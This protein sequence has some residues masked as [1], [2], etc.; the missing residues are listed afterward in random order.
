[1]GNGGAGKGKGHLVVV[2][3]TVLWSVLWS[4]LCVQVMSGQASTISAALPWLG[5]SHQERPHQCAQIGDRTRET[6][7]R[8]QRSNHWA[9]TP[10][11]HDNSL[12]RATYTLPMQLTPRRA[13]TN[14]LT[15][16]PR[17]K[18]TTAEPA[19]VTGVTAAA[20]STS[21]PPPESTS[22]PQAESTPEPESEVTSEPEGTTEPESE[23]TSEPEGTTEPE[24]EVTS[25]P[26]GTTEPESEVTS[27]PEGT[28]EPE[29]VVT[30]EP[31]GSTEPES[32][33][34]S[35][36]EGSTEPE[37][38]VTS[39]PEGTIE[40]ESVV[41][42]E[43]ERSTE[44]ESEVTSEPEGSTEPESE[45]TSEPEGTTEPE[46]VVTSEPEG[47]IEPESEVTSEP[48]GT[49]EPESE[50]TSEPEG[51]TEPESEVTSEPEGTTEPESEVTSEPEGTIEPESEVTYEPEGTTE[52][53]SEVISESEGTIEPESEV[54]SEPEG[55]IE[56][57]SEVTS[58]PE[59]STE[60]ESEVASEPEGT[61]EPESEVTSEPEGTIEPESEV[62]SEPEGSTEP[63]PGVTSE[64]EGT[65]EPESEVTSE[66]ESEGSSEPEGTTEPESEANSEPESEGSS[67]PESVLTVP[68]GRPSAA[69][70]VI[71]PLLL[72]LGILFALLVLLIK[73]RRASINSTVYG[74]SRTF[75]ETIITRKRIGC[76]SPASDDIK[77]IDLTALNNDSL[78]PAV[79]TAAAGVGAGSVAEET[80]FTEFDLDVLQSLRTCYNQ[81]KELIRIAIPAVLSLALCPLTLYMFDPFRKLVWPEYADR[82]D[83]N[84]AIACYLSPAGLV[85]ATSFGFAFQQ[86]LNKQHEI[87]TKM[88]EEISMLDQI[89]TFAIK[90][91]VQLG[92]KLKILRAVKA[93]CIFMALQVLDR[94]IV[95]YRHKPDDDIK[96]K[97]WTVVDLLREV[98]TSHKNHIDRMLSER[99][100]SHIMKLNSICS[101]RMGIL[102]SRIHPFK[103]VFLETLGFFSFLGILLLTAH[104]YRMEL[105]MCIVTVF[106][107]SMLCYVVSDLDAPF[108]GFFRVDIGVLEEVLKRLDLIHQMAK[109]R[110]HVEVFYPE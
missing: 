7:D 30:S 93:E 82:P 95:S 22:E 50:V 83:I 14:P 74:V 110:G 102:H 2:M 59:G 90:L 58:E 86:V 34:T 71:P 91:H 76:H 87:L 32:E 62:T 67:E 23:V 99:I 29:S 31:E 44:P 48:E 26:E 4:V 51:T 43:P 100:L 75:L 81:P 69:E 106:S 64:Q 104:S 1:M 37:S 96:V 35:E 18:S 97:I 63:E 98:D 103:W 3:Q 77:V 55:T 78:K 20:E 24:P 108:S 79:Q 53:E 38:E 41:T 6:L 13:L 66:P 109:H 49:I 25:E 16:A 105:V 39:E 42:S 68:E 17:H 72:I 15:W 88:T 47:S 11:H 61:I 56:P 40:P 45:V 8:M 85:Y 65:T 36:P 73:S 107:I 19:S 5:G 9:T 10:V 46:S 12:S 54:T 27:E 89:I 84:D 94:D 101:D 21:E 33:V 52:P 28:I 70:I 92:T 57:E 60:P 80:F